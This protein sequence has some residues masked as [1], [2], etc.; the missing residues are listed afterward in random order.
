MK[1]TD[2]TELAAR[3][4]TL[5][6][7]NRWMKRVGTTFAVLLVAAAVLMGSQ[8]TSSTS[9]DN[10]ALRDSNGRPRATFS[11][12]RDGPIMRFLSDSGDEIANFGMVRNNLVLRLLNARGGVQTGVSLEP[13]GVAIVSYDNN[14]RILVGPNAL[15][16]DSGIFGGPNR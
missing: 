6:S 3:L 9:N 13:L 2:F 11:M 16:S 8:Q 4:E 1:A 10:F 15:K 5:E 12:G 14:G 7:Q